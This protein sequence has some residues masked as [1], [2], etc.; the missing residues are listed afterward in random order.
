MPRISFDYPEADKWYEET[1]E[2]TSTFDI[3]NECMCLD[4]AFIYSEVGGTYQGDPPPSDMDSLSHIDIGVGNPS[5]YD[6]EEM[7]CECCNQPL[8]T[9]NY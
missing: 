3:C 1:D 4:S 2:G 7:D 6:G 5:L 9:R 8:T